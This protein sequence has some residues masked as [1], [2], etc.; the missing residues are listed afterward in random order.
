M[1]KDAQAL[2]PPSHAACTASI[3]LTG[4][5][6][7]RRASWQ[8]QA[9]YPSLS[10]LTLLS[11]SLPCLTPYALAVEPHR[12]LGRGG[13]P[14]EGCC[15]GADRGMVPSKDSLSGSPTDYEPRS[16]SPCAPAAM[17]HPF[18]SRVQVQPSRGLL[19]DRQARTWP[20]KA[21]L[22]SHP[23]Q[24]L[25]EV[26][27]SQEINTKSVHGKKASISP[28]NHDRMR[29]GSS[30]NQKNLLHIQLQGSETYIFYST[31]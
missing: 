24:R 26:N 27:R 30:Y 17:W 25:K 16:V 7:C 12:P 23:T 31:N 29:Q 2:K 18:P 9:S 8:S 11:H 13:G 6:F 19:S 20:A 5:L 4:P 14:S 1:L 15:A 10:L 3:I 22:P 21:H 28:M